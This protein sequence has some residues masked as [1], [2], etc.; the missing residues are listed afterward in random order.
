M[1]E[2]P[3]VRKILNRQ[4]IKLDFISTPVKF[5]RF[6]IDPCYVLKGE[7]GQPKTF[8]RDLLIESS[9]FKN[10]IMKENMDQYTHFQNCAVFCSQELTNEVSSLLEKM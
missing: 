9:H 5:K 2:K 3:S 4:R 7:R 1:L 6:G 8:Y 10:R